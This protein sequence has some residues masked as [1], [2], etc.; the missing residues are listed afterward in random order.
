MVNYLFAFLRYKYCFARFTTQDFFKDGEA[1]SLKCNHQVKYCL[2]FISQ[3]PC[4]SRSLT[5]VGTFFQVV[6]IPPVIKFWG[7][8]QIKK[9]LT[10]PPSPL[11]KTLPY[12]SVEMDLDCVLASFLYCHSFGESS[13]PI[14]FCQV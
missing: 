8:G 13:S 9:Q 6:N 14:L 11:L 5:L 3:S 7:V 12:N 4:D 2:Y 1:N 10:I